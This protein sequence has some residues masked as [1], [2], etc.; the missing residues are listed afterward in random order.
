MYSLEWYQTRGIHQLEYE[1]ITG[2]VLTISGSGKMLDYSEGTPPPW[3]GNMDIRS[4]DIGDGVESVGEYA[5]YECLG[6]EVI[7]LPD[8]IR[9]IG[10][11]AFKGCSI[12]LEFGNHPVNSID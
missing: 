5:F 3:S 1:E 10:Q 8:S 11:N 6:A 4:I 9:R 2:T 7:Y 12:N